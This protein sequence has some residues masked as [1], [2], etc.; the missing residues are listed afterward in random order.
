[1]AYIVSCMDV[2]SMIRAGRLVD[3]KE[4]TEVCLKQGLE[5]GDTGRRAGAPP[6]RWFGSSGASEASSDERRR[7]RAGST[8][9]GV[10]KRRSMIASYLNAL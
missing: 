4:A 10:R 1:V 7:G 3:A 2:M 6:G 8:G 5:V 9:S